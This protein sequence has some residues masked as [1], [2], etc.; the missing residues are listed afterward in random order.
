MKHCFKK[1]SI[2]ILAAIL[3]L[4]CSAFALF[5]Q[6]G[7]L[8][9]ADSFKEIRYA[10]YSGSPIQRAAYASSEQIT[11]T[12]RTD[13]YTE[14]V[15]G[16]PYYKQDNSLSNSCGPTAGAIVVGFYDKYFE[17]LIP[18]FTA[19]YPA[20]G[21]YKTNDKTYVPK[22]LQ[23][24]YSAMRCNVDDVGV[25]ETDC[26]NGL[27]QYFAGKG[28]NLS[29]TSIA[30]SNG[31]INVSTYINAINNNRPVILF[32]VATELY[33]IK[34]SSTSDTLE[35]F[36]I[37]ANHIYVGFGYREISY[38]NGSNK[39]RTDTYIHVACGRLDLNSGFIRISSTTSGIDN[40]WFVNGYV[41]SVN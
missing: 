29:Y 16:V 41:T 3:L 6:T 27:Q 25:N 24:L 1:M 33:N 31:S 12:D 20:T 15:N 26:L 39:F 30:A 8:A 19:Y 35:K 40:N 14:T 36:S 23:D 11:F 28:R 37:P 17:E 34:T 22:L 10:D 13:E 32:G 38:Y 2:G 21:K 4:V 7:N 9:F 5:N 18:D